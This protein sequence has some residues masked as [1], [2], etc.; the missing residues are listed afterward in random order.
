MIFFGR[1]MLVIKTWISKF[2]PK[3]EYKEKYFLYIIT[4]SALLFISLLT[5]L[6][7]L[8]FNENFNRSYSI[9]FFSL[10]SLGFFCL[11]FLLRYIFTGM[12]YTEIATENDYR[13]EKRAILM[14]NMSI[15][16]VLI[17]AYA[18]LSGIPSNL[19]E[20]IYLV[21]PPFFITLIMYL[22]NFVSL[23]SS[24]NKNKINE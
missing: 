10:F 8:S 17:I 9:G 3:D 19:N 12:E 6:F 13:K 18:L 23:K 11:Y 16:I 5:F 21:L 22:F 14:K 20:L 7:L 24:Y 4:E 2:L 1:M 15:L